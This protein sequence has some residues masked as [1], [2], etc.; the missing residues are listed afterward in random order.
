MKR[1]GL[2]LMIALCLCLALRAEEGMYPLSEIH[3]LDLEA[4]GF[5]IAPGELYNP[6]GVSLIDGIINLGGCTASFVSPDGLIL[7]NYHCAFGAIQS[8]STTDSDYLRDGF[9]AADC[10]AEL[11]ARRYTAR[12]I[13]SYRDVSRE[14]LAA[15]GKRMS[16]DERGQAIEEKMK[17]MVAAV[18]KANPGRRAEVAEMF[19]GK[20]YVLFIYN[21]IKD[22]RL[23]YAP[24]RAI[25]EYGGE[26]DNWMW[27]RH[28]GDFAFMRAYVAP[29]GRSADYSPQ[30]VPFRPKK[31]L[32]IAPQGV[33]AGDFV[34]ALGY[35]GST[36]RNDSSHYLAFEEEVRLPFA[37]EVWRWLID[38]KEKMSRSDR[39][40]AIKLSSSLQGLWNNVKRSEGQ[41]KGLKNLGLAN[42]RRRQEEELRRFIGADPGRRKKYGDLFTRLDQSYEAMGRRARRDLTLSNLVSSRVSMML[43]NAFAICEASFERIK[44]DTRREAPYMDR[45]FDLTE[46]RMTQAL[47]DYHEPAE[48]AVLGEMLRRA[49][50]LPRENEIAA[51]R[52]L[53]G[54][55]DPDKAIAAFLDKAFA[56]TTLKNAAAVSALLKKTTAELRSL[57]DPLIQLAITLYP[58]YREMKDAEKRQKAVLD[59]LLARLVDARKEFLGTDFVPDANGTLRLTH[60]RV[61]GYSPADAVEMQP[62]TTL[63]GI[64]E[65]DAAHPGSE[66]HGAP[67][68]FLELARS[69]EHGGYAHP[70]L[71]DV[72]VAMLYDMDTTGG[73][74][75][76]PVFN[77][78]GGLVGLN[79][80]RVYE[81]TINDFAWDQSYSRSI[82]VD[83][84]FILWFLDKYSGATRLLTEMGANR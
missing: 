34:F 62:F 18:E 60:G 5:A 81:A 58:E 1:N 10:R 57:E 20:S 49:A 33:Q 9:H 23:V 53:V 44:A 74:S 4:R 59:P 73:N 25:G 19:R 36:H 40:T 6:G 7:T 82:G 29:D 69:R 72:P 77:A 39:A 31:Y 11:P 45:N 37:I 54:A 12:L 47:R 78:R 66:N 51:V 68:R 22:V 76:S 55:G 80:D 41:L 56:A 43:G 63:A 52:A 24:P 21:N 26:E 50:A 64:A 16:P 83:I 14:V 15:A 84:R 67:A 75:G 28:T 38:L 46:K 8:L 42:K 79:F 65:K 17:T 70:Q 35:P 13:E 32:A 48:K 61:R 27:P 3:K 30:N 2:I 71:G